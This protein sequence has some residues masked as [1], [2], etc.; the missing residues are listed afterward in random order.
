MSYD[1]VLYFAVSR[2]FD[3]KEQIYGKFGNHKVGGEKTRFAAYNTVNPSYKYV[4]VKYNQFIIEKG[5]QAAPHQYLDNYINQTVLFKSSTKPLVKF[6]CSNVGNMHPEISNRTGFGGANRLLR[7]G[8]G[9]ANRPLCAKQPSQNRRTQLDSKEISPRYT[10]WFILTEHAAKNILSYMIQLNSMKPYNKPVP[11][12]NRH[13]YIAF[14]QAICT[15]LQIHDERLIQSQTKAHT[16]PVFTHLDDKVRNKGFF[17][18]CP[19]PP[20]SGRG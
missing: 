18:L 7:A 11:L 19:V 16:P 8:F 5:S 20:L 6:K 1:N 3:N 9:G 2:D 14:V 13:D 4:A 17:C 10:D 12:D 15:Y